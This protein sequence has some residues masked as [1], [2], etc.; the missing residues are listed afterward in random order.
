ME[1]LLLS[2]IIHTLPQQGLP[3]R[4][5]KLVLK[6][7]EEITQQYFA[8]LDSHLSDLVSGRVTEMLEIGQIA[9]ILCITPKHLSETITLVKGHHPCYYYDRK[10]AEQAKKL[11]T[12]TNASVAEIA[13]I[14][15]YDPSNFSKFFK[16]FTG[17]TP[18]AFR[19]K[20]KI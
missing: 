7:N 5:R 4:V 11:L 2:C 13:R 9:A 10:I 18:G 8:L 14:L 19:Q 17:E 6:R 15:T 1:E 3:L 20:N 16:K 12:E